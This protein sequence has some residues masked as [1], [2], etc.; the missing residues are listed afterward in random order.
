MLLGWN[1]AIIWAMCGYPQ[2]IMN[3]HK[4]STKGFSVDFGIMSV[5]GHFLYM[6]YVVTGYVY[7]KMGTGAVQIND[8]IYP[9]QL[10]MTT[11]ICMVQVFIYNKEEDIEYSKNTIKFCLFI[12]GIIAIMFSIEIVGGVV[13]PLAYNTIRIIGYCNTAI[14][15]V[16]YMPQAMLNYER[17]STEGLSIPFFFMDFIG[18][19]FSIS[20][21]FIDMM[22]VVEVTGLWDNFTIFSPNFNLIKLFIGLLTVA[23]DLII[24]FQHFVLY[25]SEEEENKSLKE[26]LMTSQTITT[27]FI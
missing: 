21:Q 15:L 20:Q 7:P 12:V 19:I 10:F 14:L 25:P 27:D 1:Y 2:I 24:G 16:K 22:I 6:L 23:F 8:V 18:A 3:Y 11:T 5:L 9:F 17:K 4:K 26:R 13:L